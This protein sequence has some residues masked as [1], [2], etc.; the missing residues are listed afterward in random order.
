MQPNT[1]NTSERP[2]S[3]EVRDRLTRRLAFAVRSGNPSGSSAS[4]LTDFHG[5]AACPAP[6]TVSPKMLCVVFGEG[7][8][9]LVCPNGTR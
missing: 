9:W 3:R 5:L 6:L 4:N 1:R 2:L 7:V 8:R